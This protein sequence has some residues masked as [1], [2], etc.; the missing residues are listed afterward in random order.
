MG[1]K[2]VILTGDSRGVARNIAGQL[3]LEEFVAEVSPEQK[4]DYIL[5]LQRQGEKVGMVGGSVNDALALSIADVGFAMGAG[6]D[7]AIE[8]ADIALLSNSVGFRRESYSNLEILHP[9]Y[10]SKLGRRLW[11]QLVAYT[12]RRQGVVSLVRLAY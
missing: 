7:I 5:E 6:T 2:V 8:S 11:L 12:R 4:L 1:L 3:A 10:L 9:E